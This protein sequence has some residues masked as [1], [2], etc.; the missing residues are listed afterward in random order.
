MADYQSFPVTIGTHGDYE[1]LVADYGL[2][3]LL[4]LSPE[5]VLGK[6]VAIT[7]IDSGSLNP[8][9]EERAAGWESRGGIAYSPKIAV[10]ETLPH[11]GW[12]EW[13]VFDHLVDLGE[14]AS[15]DTNVF[16]SPITPGTV[17]AFVNFNF[18]P[19]LTDDVLTDIFWQQLDWIRPQSYI[20]ENDACLTVMSTDKHLFNAARE[21]LSKLD[22]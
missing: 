7:S 2:D 9:E 19:H 15:H 10:I 21:A 20:A 1:W 17:H 13:W 18:A 8:T 5:I 3:D 6:Y 4:R 16:E 11:E 12:D 14:L 22:L